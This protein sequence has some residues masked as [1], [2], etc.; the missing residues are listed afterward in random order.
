VR[1]VALALALTLVGACSSAGSPKAAAPVDRASEEL[2][3]LEVVFRYQFAHHFSFR[4]A[5]QYD[6]IFLSLPGKQDPTAAFLSRFAGQ[7]PHVEP[8][9]AAAADRWMG[10]HDKEKGGRGILFRVNS[11]RWIDDGAVE[12]DGGHYESSRNA[13]FTLYQ[14]ERRS[15]AWV[16]VSDRTYGAG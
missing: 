1:V 6:C 15:G 10:I 12:V 13:S 16:V 4:S 5:D 9:S 3:I 14:V 11:L 7:V 2:D 8:A